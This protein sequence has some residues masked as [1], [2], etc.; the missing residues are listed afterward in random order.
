MT[1]DFATRGLLGEDGLN[2]YAFTGLMVGSAISFAFLGDS[3]V[4]LLI[5]RS[6]SVPLRRCREGDVSQIEIDTLP[7]MGNE[8]REVKGRHSSISRSYAII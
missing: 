1:D 4:A 7:R 6:I 5:L 2:P 3:S 8:L